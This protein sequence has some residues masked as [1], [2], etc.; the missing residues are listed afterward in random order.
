MK[1]NLG[2]GAL[3]SAEGRK[4]V[5]GNKRSVQ[6]EQTKQ[7]LDSV[8]ISDCFQE[9]LEAAAQ[10]SRQINQPASEAKIS[11]LKEAVDSGRYL[12]DCHKLAHDM[13]DLI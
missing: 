10:V 12:V 5:K 1:I 11:E 8:E 2:I 4:E 13:I 9:C 7:S 3:L 6:S